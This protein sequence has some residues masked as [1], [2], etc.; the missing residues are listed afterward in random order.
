MFFLIFPGERCP[1]F[2]Y[3]DDQKK[4]LLIW[5]R[6]QEVLQKDSTDYKLSKGLPLLEE[7]GKTIL[8]ESGEN[9]INASAKQLFNFFKGARK[10]VTNYT[11]KHSGDAASKGIANESAVNRLSYAAFH[12]EGIIRKNRP[13]KKTP[14]VSIK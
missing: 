14:H 3:T 11:A 1:A 10:W 2:R 7:K 12:H 4:E 13:G 6:D 5:H 8:G 9:G